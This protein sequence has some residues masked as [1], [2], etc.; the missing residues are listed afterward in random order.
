MGKN[1][2]MKQARTEKGLSQEALAAAVGVS[3]QTINAIEKG[4]Y[5]PTI[6][7]CISICRVLGLTL[8]DLFWDPEE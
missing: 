1:L 4:D 6:R 5:N 3:R 2:A 7:L 8:N